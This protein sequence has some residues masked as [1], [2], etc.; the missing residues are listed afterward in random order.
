MTLWKANNP[1]KEI[2]SRIAITS[3]GI[4]SDHYQQLIQIYSK[5]KASVKL[6]A[7]NEIKIVD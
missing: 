7:N 4:I 3:S 2:I 6:T 1:T 5:F